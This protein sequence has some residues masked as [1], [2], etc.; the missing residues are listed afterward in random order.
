MLESSQD[1]PCIGGNQSPQ[2][3]NSVPLSHV[4]VPP[5]K[6]SLFF[7]SGKAS[8]YDYIFF[9]FFANLE[10]EN[11]NKDQKREGRFLVLDSV[12]TG[13]IARHR[14]M[15]A[16]GGTN[17]K[18]L[19]GGGT[20]SLSSLAHD[21]GDS[22]KFLW[23]YRPSRGKGDIEECLQLGSANCAGATFLCNAPL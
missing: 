17:N 18:V 6:C 5:H 13:F 20:E 23:R 2:E 15:E 14:W 22:L 11:E 21:E 12:S 3:Q 16:H 1:W 10:S 4:P 9:S 19:S 7:S 8:K